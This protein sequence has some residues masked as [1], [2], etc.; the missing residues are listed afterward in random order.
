MNL[1]SIFGNIIQGFSS[2]EE[3]NE[4]LSGA[5]AYGMGSLIFE[6]HINIDSSKYTINK[7]SV[8]PR[9]FIKWLTNLN[10]AIILSGNIK[11]R[12]KN[13]NKEQKDISKFKRGTYLKIFTLRKEI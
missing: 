5:L 13:L 6:K 8:T 4:T 1:R 11:N 2:H 9:N 10:H 12:D 3:P 7:Y